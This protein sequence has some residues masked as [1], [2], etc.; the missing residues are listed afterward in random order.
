MPEARALLSFDLEEFDIPQE[1]GR[2]VAEATQ[3]QV[4]TEGLLPLLDLLD[5]RDVAATFF[6]TA[7]YALHHVELMRR[8]AA[9]HEVA[10]HGVHHS[11]WTDDDL[12]Q[13]RRLLA[14]LTG[15]RVIGFRMPR[16]APV[17]AQALRQAGYRYNSSLNPTWLPGRYN[18]FFS[19]RKPHWQAGVLQIPVSV[20]PLVRYP[21]FWLSVK[22]GP[23]L[24]TR[25]AARWV[26]R[27]DGCVNFYF[28]PWE[29]ADIRNFGLPRYIARRCGGEA[30]ARLEALV[31][32]L[33]S[34]GAR[35]TRFDEFADAFPATEENA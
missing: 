34:R 32:W 12:A 28:H 18:H 26:L 9:R 14:E 31:L 8:I 3:F 30:L 10:S 27:A 33:S 25:A 20:T 5:R 13:S 2:P 1:F 7:N 22:N 15:Q 19:P 16:L 21:L 23:L 24:A 17:Q 29:F 11:R 35:F 6:T 4:T